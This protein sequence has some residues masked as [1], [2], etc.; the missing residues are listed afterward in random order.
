[1]KKAKTFFEIDV[2]GDCAEYPDCPRKDKFDCRFALKLPEIY[3]RLYRWYR[4]E[5]KKNL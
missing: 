1:M 2:C 3:E 5:S 4:K